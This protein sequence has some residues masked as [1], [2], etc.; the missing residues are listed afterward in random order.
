MRSLVGGKRDAGDGHPVG[1]AVPAKKMA[2]EGKAHEA[3]AHSQR[4]QPMLGS[5]P[6]EGEMTFGDF[7]LDSD[8]EVSD[9]EAQVPH[10]ARGAELAS[11][12]QNQGQTR[13]ENVFGLLANP[14]DVVQRGMSS[15]SGRPSI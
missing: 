8:L 9:E 15:S 1:R 3:A 4:L 11:A 7:G 14:T 2:T 5:T 12:L 13:P 10:W 6:V